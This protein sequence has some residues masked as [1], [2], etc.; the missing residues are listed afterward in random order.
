MMTRNKVIRSLFFILLIS[1]ILA[2]SY[3]LSTQIAGDTYIEA[4]IQSYG[5]LGVLILGFITGL[6]I[7]IPVP[8]ASFAPIFI[9]GGMSIFSI[10]A[11]LIIGTM[12]ANLLSFA[13]GHFG[14]KVACSYHPEAQE[15]FL[16]LYTKHKAYLPYLIFGFT[17]FVPF[18]DE[19]YLIPLGFLGIRLRVIILPLFLGTVVYQTLTAFGFTSFFK[20]ISSL[21]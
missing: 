11:L 18:P 20:F 13:I 8:A 19:I 12:A 3:W 7:L 4:V 1:T 16:E 5:G 2:V 14:H 10:I 17:A 6:N 15:K 9:A 21:L